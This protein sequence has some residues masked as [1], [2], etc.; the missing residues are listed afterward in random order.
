MFKLLDDLYPPDITRFETRSKIV[1]DAEGQILRTFTVE[2]G[3]WRLSVKPDDVS[4]NYLDMLIAFE[5]KRFWQHHGVDLLAMMRAISQIIVNGRVISG[6]STLTMQVARLL[7]PR[8]RTIE[9][10]LIEIFRSVQLEQRYTKEEILEFYLTLAPFGGNIEGVRAATL[11]YFNKEPKWLTPGEAALLA[12]LPQSPTYLRPDTHP[13]NAREAR[14]KV[15]TRA[16]QVNVLSEKITNES[17]TEPIPDKKFNMAFEAPLFAYRL[18]KTS[19]QEIYRTFIN[20]QWQ[21]EIETL[22]KS[23]VNRLDPFVSTAILVIDNTNLNV[24]SYVGSSDFFSQKRDGQV[25]MVRAVRSP[26]STLKPFIYGV[27]FDD[28]LI[29]PGTIVHDVPTLFGNYAP[30]NFNR[31]FA[32]DVTAATALQASLNVPAVAVLE[33]V[34]P[35]RFAQLLKNIDAPLRIPGQNLSPSLPIAI[36][37]VGFTLEDL[38]KLYAGIA[39]NGEVA[40]LNFFANQKHEVE[41]SPFLSETTATYLRSILL[42]IRRPVGF[43]PTEFSQLQQKIAFKTGTSYGYRDAWAIGFSKSYTIGVWVGRPDGTPH[44][45]FIGLDSSKLMLKAFDIVLADR[46][47]KPLETAYIPAPP[48]GLKAYPKKSI[49]ISKRGQ[50]D[51]FK[52]LFPPKDTTLSLVQTGEY[53]QPIILKA[54]AGKRPY[55]W[56]INGKPTGSSTLENRMT[57]HPGEPGAYRITAIDAQGNYDTVNVWLRE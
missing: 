17:K 49:I 3:I 4:S 15:L 35:K 25:D 13:N 12:A 9:S 50:I 6:G 24:I 1:L 40:P 57:W 41:S 46:P 21:S 44:Y 38:V 18:T 31:D 36:G 8:P 26:G 34:G 28:K 32:G 42:D 51:G 56:L 47:E 7:E 2:D 27:A 23:Y 10:K 29:H 16:A 45:N 48:N 52:I 22:A 33:G 14:N 39:R 20:R 54:H 43:M 19:D 37:G 30:R 5:D 11:Q 55:R 53:F